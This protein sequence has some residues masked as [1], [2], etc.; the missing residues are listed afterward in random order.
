M[1]AGMR[2]D[3]VFPRFKVL[4]G[5]ERLVLEASRGGRI[6]AAVLR[7]PLVYGPGNR[8]NIPRMLSALEAGRLPPLPWRSNR[9]SIVSLD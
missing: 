3:F 8:G 4:S 9:R 2:L 6:R 5:A 1:S 7:L